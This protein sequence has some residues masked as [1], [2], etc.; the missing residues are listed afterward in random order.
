MPFVYE[1]LVPL[2]AGVRVV[3]IPAAEQAV[4]RVYRHHRMIIEGAGGVGLAAAEVLAAEG[5]YR[6]IAAILSGGNIDNQALSSILE[7]VPYE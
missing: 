6:H 2:I 5:R 7:R 4:A 3:S 1:R